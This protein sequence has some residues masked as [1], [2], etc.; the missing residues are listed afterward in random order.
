MFR[1]SQARRGSKRSPKTVVKGNHWGFPNDYLGSVGE[2]IN[3]IEYIRDTFCGKFTY[4][5][6]L[7]ADFGQKKL[8]FEKFIEFQ[9]LSWR[10]LANFHILQHFFQDSNHSLPPK[11]STHD[12]DEIS[13]LWAHMREEKSWNFQLL[14]WSECDKTWIPG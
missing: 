13:Q 2:K 5:M 11:F 7:W 12:F 4:Y 6:Q 1:P 10:Q 8:F 9:I 14:K 3:Y